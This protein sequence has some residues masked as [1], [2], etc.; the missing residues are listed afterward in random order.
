MLSGPEIPPRSKNKP[1]NLVIFLHGVGADG[2]NIADI[3]NVLNRCVPDTYFLCPN[4]A[5]P[6]DLGIGG[7]QW[8]SLQDR[9]ESV[10]LEGINKTLPIVNEY[11]DYNLSK[12]SLE[13]K[14]LAIMGFS[15]GC[16]MALHLGLRRQKAPACVIGFSGALIGAE[17]LKQQQLRKPPIF[18]AHGDI[19]PIVDV[20]QMKIAAKNLKMMGIK[21]ET[22]IFKNLL[23]GMNE[24]CLSLAVDKLTTSFFK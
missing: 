17:F 15:Q 2:N 11:I 19:D 20:E 16:M 18:L 21:V 10:L 4:G 3:C 14:N 13:D 5:F 9:T 7:Y 23:H 24:K 6:Y 22:H 12:Y 8:F 1:K